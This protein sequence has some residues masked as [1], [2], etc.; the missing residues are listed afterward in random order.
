MKNLTALIAS[1]LTGLFLG[2]F[3]KIAYESNT[4]KPYAWNE[5]PIV[6]N[7]YGKKFSKLHMT[8]AI[9]CWAIR[10]HHFGSYIHNPD[11]EM[12]EKEWKE[13]YIIIRIDE[14]MSSETLAR[15]KRY[16]SLHKITGAV[17]KFKPKSFN[18]YLLNEHELGHALGYSHVEK[19]G[20]V[21]HPI[22]ESMGLDFYIN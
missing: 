7:C 18:L 9:E 21:M 3:V 14:T 19:K 15:T 8:R 5:P 10:N 17:I 6:L 13:G 4:V 22:H 16:T 11:P 12:C 2:F 20:H 1:L